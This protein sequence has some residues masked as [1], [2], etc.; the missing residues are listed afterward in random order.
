M[1][2]LAVLLFCLI[3]G[4]SPGAAAAGLVETIKTIKPSIVGVGTF[5][6]LRRPSNE[7]RGTGFIVGDGRHV[8]T[9][10]HV[11][12]KKVVPGSRA[13]LAVFI[14]TGTTA[15][16][17]RAEIL[18]S[19]KDHDIALLRFSGKPAPAL[20]LNQGA[21]AEE[22]TQIAFSGFPI[23]AVY[24]LYPVTHRGIISAIT[25]VAIPQAVSNRLSAAMIHR[26][27]AR[28]NVYQL[29]ATAYPGNSGSPV[30]DI[31]SGLVIG[32]VSSVFIKET[33]ENLLSKPSGITL[34]V[35]ISYAVRLMRKMN[36][37]P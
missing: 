18:A 17:R 10:N 3:A 2:R 32:I 16:V 9:N 31:R 33:R 21:M 24:G 7:L 25:P 23:G 26:L 34:A 29:D 5:D 15:L 6:P 36:V 12:A 20:R 27:A 14:G 4:A 28:Y 19:D 35:P 22:G 8:L 37:A 13:V 1:T 30:Y 11:V